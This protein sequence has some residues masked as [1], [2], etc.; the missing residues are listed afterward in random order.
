MER[1]RALLVEDTLHGDRL[2]R[3]TLSGPGSRRISVVRVGTLGA[4]TARLRSG[5]IDIVVLDLQ[6]HEG[7]VAESVARLHA[8]APQVPIVVL[9]KGAHEATQLGAESDNEPQ[10]RLRLLSNETQSP[11]ESGPDRRR[12]A[13]TEGGAGL[14]ALSPCGRSL[15]ADDSALE[16]LG[17]TLES[18]PAQWPEFPVDGA[19]P[20]ELQ[21]AHGRVLELHA[22]RGE[23]DHAPAWIGTLHDITAHVRARVGLERALARAVAANAGLERL[24]SIDPLTGLLNRRGLEAA[25]ARECGRTGRSGEPIAA[26]LI[27]CD[28]FKRVNDRA[29]QSVGDLVLQ[30]V[31]RRLADS[32]RPGDHLGRIG[33]DEFLVLLPGTGSAEAFRVAQRLR[34]AVAG[35]PLR[36]PP[37][38]VGVTVSLGLALLSDGEASL[39]DVLERTAGSLRRSK[40]RGKNRSSGAASDAEPHEDELADLLDERRAGSALHVERRPLVRLSDETVCAWELQPRRAPGDFARRSQFLRLALELDVLRRVDL[41]CLDACAREAGLMPGGVRCHIA[42]HPSTVLESS[43]ERLMEALA[44]HSD[45]TRYCLEISEQE[46]VGDPAALLERRRS[47]REAGILLAIGDV[48]CGRSSLENLIVL[49]PD[50]VKLEPDFARRSARGSDRSRALGR[51]IRL[52]AALGCELVVD[53]I[54]T[55][56]DLDAL[57]ARGV[58]YGQ[59]GLW[60][61]AAATACAPQETHAEVAPAAERPRDA[62]LVPR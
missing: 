11:T 43:F 48:G 35:E 21:G 10:P 46:L 59:G 37:G 57:R 30:Q 36:V 61:R 8:T 55:R 16:L 62:R 14:V 47:L 15:F 6:R 26:L 12:N 4:A 1:I 22:T 24:A 34:L 58:L 39:E 42:V 40:R 2:V 23:W 45:V 49:E 33:G 17:A 60:G 38:P 52:V 18:L 29:G 44:P 19:F 31:S 28:D 27:D 20:V 51:M 54:A 5:D 56:A 53:G 41:Q 7:A 50:L 3:A 13:R 25:L 9:R 32:L